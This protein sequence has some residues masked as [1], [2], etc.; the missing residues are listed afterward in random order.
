MMG[1]V[2][3]TSKFILDEISKQIIEQLQQDGRRAYAAIGKAVGLSEAAVRQ[4]VQRM[5]EAGVIQIVAVTDPVQVGFNR[6][7]MIGIRV[8]G[9]INDI[10]AAFEQMLEIEYVVIVAGGFDLIIEVVCEDD[11]GLLD[12]LARIRRVPGVLASETFVYLKLHKQHYDWG[13]R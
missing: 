13:T 10:V 5:V 11:A 1:Q 3:E 8:S 9:D 7:A 4:R 12:L 2:A 6:Q